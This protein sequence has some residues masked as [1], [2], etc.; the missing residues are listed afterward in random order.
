MSFWCRRWTEHSRSPRW[1]T[2]PCSSATICI[3]MWRG[4]STYRSMYIDAVA[5]RGERLVLTRSRRPARSALALAD[6]L[7]AAP[8]AAGRR[9]EDDREA[10][11]LGD[12]LRLL[13]VL[14]LAARAG[15]ER[16]AGLLGR[17]ARARPCCPSAGSSPAAG[18]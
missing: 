6:D 9:L 11:L 2:L 5:E 14:E 3:S 16:Q 18:R 1:I 8:A 12:P 7:H 13:G 10:D 15:Q 17:L 4:F